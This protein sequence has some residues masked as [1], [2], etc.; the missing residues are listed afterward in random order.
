MTV[1]AGYVS[2]KQPFTIK[3]EC[4]HSPRVN[5]TFTGS[6]MAGTND[7]ILLSQYSGNPN[8]GIQLKY[9]DNY[10]TNKI[11]VKNGTAFRVL[12]NAGTHET[13]N[14]NSSYYYKGGGSP[15]S[16]GPVKANAEFIFTYP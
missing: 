5:V 9:I 10:S 15:V 2:A 8:I 7:V 6:T 4:E 1:R 12:Q 11:I 13:L 3:L 16:G 14:F